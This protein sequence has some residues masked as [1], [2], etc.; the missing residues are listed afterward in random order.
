LPLPELRTRFG[1]P[2]PRS[3]PATAWRV[4]H[5]LALPLIAVAAVTLTLLRVG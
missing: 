4:G 5:A 2:R 3:L 1:R